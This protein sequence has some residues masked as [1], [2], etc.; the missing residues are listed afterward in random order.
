MPMRSGSKQKAS[1]EQ[2][3]YKKQEQEAQQPTTTNRTPQR[4]LR[5]A[6]KACEYRALPDDERRC[7]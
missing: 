1:I 3:T 6:G 4:M 7:F 5:S 2:M